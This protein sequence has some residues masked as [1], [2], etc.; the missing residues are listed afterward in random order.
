MEGD[1]E[2]C[3]C[4]MKP[5][6]CALPGLLI[7]CASTGGAPQDHG[8]AAKQLPADLYQDA[9]P[10]ARDLAEAVAQKLESSL[11]AGATLVLAVTSLPTEPR[12]SKAIEVLSARL[13]AGGRIRVSKA[14]GFHYGEPVSDGISGGH[15]HVMVRDWDP[16]PQLELNVYEWQGRLGCTAYQFGHGPEDTPWAIPPP[17]WKVPAE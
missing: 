1:D 13:R 16:A 4:T 9:E 8:G 15:V 5:R 6:L 11:P 17:L 10:A 14:S 3:S 7:A 2:V 12:V